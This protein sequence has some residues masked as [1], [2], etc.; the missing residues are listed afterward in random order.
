MVNKKPESQELDDLVFPFNVSFIC[1]NLESSIK[2]TVTRR[3]QSRSNMHTEAVRTTKGQIVHKT[4]N[5]GLAVW[6]I[7]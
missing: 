3:L 1:K 6:Q 7:T 5:D 2:L 4:L